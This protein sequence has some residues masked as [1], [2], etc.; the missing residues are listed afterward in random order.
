MTEAYIHYKNGKK[1]KIAAKGKLQENGEWVEAIAYTEEGKTDLYFRS[2]KEFLEK[3]AE[4]IEI[5]C[6][7]NNGNG[8]FQESCAINCGCIEIEE[9]FR[10]R[11]RVKVKDDTKQL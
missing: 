10:E 11:K 6:T 4:Q 8:C 2:E 9:N 1:Y 7:G 3:F 5:Q